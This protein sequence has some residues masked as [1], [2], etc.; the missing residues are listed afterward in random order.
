MANQRDQKNRT[1]YI[2]AY[3]REHYYRVTLNL[4]KVND[5]DI[6]EAIKIAE[7][8]SGQR[9]LK[10]YIRRAMEVMKD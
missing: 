1:K 6:I 7:A 2:T 10:E 8:E 5:K 9:C 4:H 3:N